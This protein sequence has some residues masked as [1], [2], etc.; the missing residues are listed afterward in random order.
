MAGNQNAKMQS[1]VTTPRPTKAPSI[2]GAAW[3]CLILG[4]VA[5]LVPVPGFSS[6]VGWPLSVVAT[7][8]A[9]VSIAKGGL[10]KGLGALL[11]SLI[12][13]PIIYF[14]GLAIMV[15]VVIKA[16]LGV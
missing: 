7:I 4:W 3:A 14:L 8:L 2:V 16:Q 13:S 11:C 6:F 5:F 12:F 1:T 10:G 9:T 15:R